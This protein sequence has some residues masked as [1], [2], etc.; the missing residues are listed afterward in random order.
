MKKIIIIVIFFKFFTCVWTKQFGLV[1]V[2]DRLGLGTVPAR[3]HDRDQSAGAG[4]DAGGRGHLRS[5][6]FEDR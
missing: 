3:T 6:S 5:P 1:L 2:V 4:G